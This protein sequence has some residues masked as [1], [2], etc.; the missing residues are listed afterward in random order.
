MKADQPAPNTV[1]DYIAGFP[2]DVQ[3]M[4]EKIRATVRKAAPKAEETIS[5]MMPAFKLHGALVYFAA[6][7]NHIGFYPGP[8]GIDAFKE[9]LSAYELSKGTIRFP[10]DKPVPLTLIGKIV[11]FRV[12]QNLEKAAAKAARGKK[13]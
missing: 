1:D 4:L 2:T 11:K 8:G 12:Q 5:Y 7:K 6:Y 3:A 13:K 10:L 9:E